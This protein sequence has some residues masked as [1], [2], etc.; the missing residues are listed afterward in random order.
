MKKKVIKDP[1]KKQPCESLVIDGTKYKTILNRKFERRIPWAR[2]NPKMVTSYLPGMIMK[3][4]VNRGQKVKKG[5]DLL[6]FEAM[7]M[8]NQVK[9]Q[10]AGT[11]K[12]ILVSEGQKIAKGVVMIEFK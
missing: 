9:S 4:A 10:V 1:C 7:K 2:P 11:V 12:N 5:E 8:K 3:I 6:V